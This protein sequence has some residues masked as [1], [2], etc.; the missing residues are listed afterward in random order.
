MTDETRLALDKVTT[1]FAA[2]AV[3]R[4][5]AA[6]NSHDPA[7]LV[8]LCQPDVEWED[9]AIEGGHM[10]GLDALRDWLADMY[11]AFP[12]LTFEVVEPLFV[13]ADGRSFGQQ[14]SA[15]ATMR[16]PYLGMEPT[17]RAVDFDGIDLHAYREGSLAS[18]RTIYNQMP[19][20]V[21]VAAA[22]EPGSK[23][24]HLGKRMQHLA[25]RR[26]RKH[27]SD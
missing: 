21:Q 1:E 4:F 3:R 6:W 17:Q 22:P 11:A 9:P 7:L 27:P 16:G 8:E 10:T 26:M 12:D 25:A 13:A 18:V 20:A 15:H 2:E 19:V 24:D 14:W 5:V 23:L